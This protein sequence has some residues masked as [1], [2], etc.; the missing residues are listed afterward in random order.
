MHS[1]HSVR[2]CLTYSIK[3]SVDSFW[4][5]YVWVMIWFWFCCVCRKPHFPKN[6]NLL[7]VKVFHTVFRQPLQSP[8]H[9]IHIQFWITSGDKAPP[10]SVGI[11]SFALV[12]SKVCNLMFNKQR[13]WEMVAWG[14]VEISHRQGLRR[15]REV[16]S[17]LLHNFLSGLQF[18]LWTQFWAA[19][20]VVTDLK[21]FVVPE[22]V[23]R[24]RENSETTANSVR[25]QSLRS[26]PVSGGRQI[27][28]IPAKS[29]EYDNRPQRDGF[30]IISR[31]IFHFKVKSMPTF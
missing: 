15:Q 30:T 28:V 14:Q 9:T 31:W 1:F 26:Q 17:L 2:T 19:K 6:G 23:V 18:D 5:A 22:V 13:S 12:F 20:S 25:K 7:T 11:I 4:F 29:I 21:E 8:F 24:S 10:V 3:T 27:Q 16:D